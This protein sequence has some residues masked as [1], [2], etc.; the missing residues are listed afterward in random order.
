MSTSTDTLSAQETAALWALDFDA[1]VP[2]DNEEH[3]E[4]RNGCIPAEPGRWRVLLMHFTNECTPT[5]FVLC[6]G[7]MRHVQEGV[8]AMFTAPPGFA[9]AVAKCVACGAIMRGPADMFAVIGEV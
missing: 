5:P 7:N 3:D 4:G 8:A 9:I 6:D 1:A 2:C